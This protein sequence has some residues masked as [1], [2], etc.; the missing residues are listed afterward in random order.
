MV[1]F[2]RVDFLV[3]LFDRLLFVLDNASVDVNAVVV[4]HPGSS[5][6][7][8]TDV[9]LHVDLVAFVDQVDSQLI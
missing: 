3:E 7:L 1:F 5:H 6:L 8:G 2:E 9:A 4:R